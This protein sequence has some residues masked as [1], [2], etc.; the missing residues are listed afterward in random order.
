MFR[1][2]D[3]A[4]MIFI[5]IEV[6]VFFYEIFQPPYAAAGNRT[7]DRVEP[8]LGTLFQDALPTELK[9]PGHLK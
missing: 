9:W 6:G 4:A 1:P 5:F 3:G 8:F 2:T 7:K